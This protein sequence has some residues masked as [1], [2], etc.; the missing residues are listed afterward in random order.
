MNAA[1]RRGVVS[2]LFAGGF[3]L[4]GVATA[5]SASADT[6]DQ[7]LAVLGSTDGA[8]G[9]G[10]GNQ[11]DLD[12]EA[13][14]RAVGNQVTALGRHNQNHSTTAGAPAAPAP[15]PAAAPDDTSG[16]D[17]VLS[18]NQTTVSAC[19]PVTADGNQ[20]TLVGDGN[21]GSSGGSRDACE[22]VTVGDAGATSGEDGVGSGNQTSIDICVPVTVSGNQV[23]GVGDDNRASSGGSGATCGAKERAPGETSGEDGLVSGNQTSL[24]VCVPVTATGNQL[25]VVGDD[26][27][28]SSS[29]SG[30]SCGE[31][32][33]DGGTPGD[34]SGE[35]GVGS[36]NQTVLDPMVP[37]DATGNQV[38]V[39]GDGNANDSSSGGEGDGT[40]GSGT[41][42]TSGE[43]GVGS[44]NQTVLDPTVPVDVIGNQVTVIGDGNTNDSTSSGGEGDGT[45]GSG[46]GDTSGEDG[47]G[48]GN[49]T[50]V[51]PTV[52]VDVIGDQITVIGDGNANDS[53]DEGPGQ[54]PGDG[55]DGD[56][57]DGDGPGDG[58]GGQDG[59]DDSPGDTDVLPGQVRAGALVAAPRAP[60]AVSAG[61][62]AAS[63]AAPASWPAGPL[64]M[65]LL[66][67]L[68]VALAGR[69]SWVTRT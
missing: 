24:D 43:G 26:N 27:Q 44:G 67:A 47:V 61:L 56:D 6:G 13:P 8:G 66:G 16:E 42:D 36:G 31:D 39:I 28:S 37:V 12:L 18:G 51:D 64:L 22:S 46:T 23:T 45:G 17:G 59:G 29:G 4:L 62:R 14:V 53:T 5:T 3:V 11:T 32:A 34:T 10:S 21:Q 55:D 52:P 68:C 38:T 19:A 41:G 2:G 60:T 25:T 63:P 65:L 7:G 33:A 15:R 58:P 57:G 49:Q 69:R 48:S 20:V 40:G 9:I 50:V 35:G 54:D 30:S 1:L